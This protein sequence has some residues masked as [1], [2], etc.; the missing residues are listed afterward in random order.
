M[1]ITGSLGLLILVIGT[2]RYYQ[3]S[4]DLERGLFQI[5]RRTPII[6]G[7]AVVLAALSVLPLLL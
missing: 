5:S 7:G 1:L 3:V 2:R 6:I 4:R